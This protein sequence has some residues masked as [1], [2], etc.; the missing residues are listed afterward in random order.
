MLCSKYN[1]SIFI[2]ATES[3][4]QMKWHTGSKVSLLIAYSKAN[5]IFNPFLHEYSC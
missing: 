3:M 5:S 4:G 1:I 2:I